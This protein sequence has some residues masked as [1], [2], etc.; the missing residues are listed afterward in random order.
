MTRLWILL[1]L[2]VMEGCFLR[3]Q[4]AGFI[5]I[6]EAH[7]PPGN[8]RPNLPS[9]DSHLPRVPNNH[10][11][12]PLELR[13]LEVK[14][15]IREQLA[16]TRITQEFYNPSSERLEGIFVFPIPKGA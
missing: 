11:F 8:S 16:V 13:N 12:S 5:I 6:D 3:V 2:T 10:A 15:D 4:A 1:I 14:T 7:W 9:R